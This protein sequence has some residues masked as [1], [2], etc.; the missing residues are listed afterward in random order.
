V[1]M[2]LTPRP[3]G[4]PLLMMPYC[5]TSLGVPERKMSLTK[6]ELGLGQGVQAGAYSERVSGTERAWGGGCGGERELGRSCLP[7]L[8]LINSTKV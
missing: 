1:A 6:M 4:L 8:A 7:S 2:E 3:S 5:V